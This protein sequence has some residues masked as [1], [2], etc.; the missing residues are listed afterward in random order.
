MYHPGVLAARFD[1]GG[2][3]GV[4]RVEQSVVISRP[5]EEVFAFL[6]DF[7]NWP[8]WLPAFRDGGEHLNG[9]PGVGDSFRQVIEIRSQP[10]RLS[11]T[12]IGYEPNDRLSLRYAWKDL[13]F[14]VNFVLKP[15]DGGTRVTGTGGGR[16][17]GFLALFEPL[18][19]REA[20]R[21]VRAN[22]ENL[23]RVLEP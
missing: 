23:R 22:L 12:V 21:E 11:G 4:V 7:G 5:P 1:V 2:D 19:E 3:I 6:A 9:P 10:V 17:D 15:T 20:N 13:L 18:V 8:R 14:D 16:L